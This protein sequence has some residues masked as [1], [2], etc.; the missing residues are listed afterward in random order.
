ML[1]LKRLQSTPVTVITI[2]SAT[3]LFV[4]STVRHLLFQSTAFEMGIYDQVTY[5][6]S[7]GLPPFSTFLEVH[8]LGNHAAWS[9]YPVALFYKIYPSVYWL[10]LIQ[11]I[12]LAIGALPTWSLARHTGLNKKQSFA[13]A[14]VYLLYPVVF[15]LN[16]FDFHPEVMALPAILGAI[17]AAKL[18]KTVWFSI[19]IIWVLGCKAVLSLPIAA[20]GFWLYFFEKKRLCGAIALF[21]GSA[22]FIIAAQVMIPFFRGG[23][24]PGGLGR[25]EYLGDSIPG[26]LLNMFLRPELVIGRVISLK[27]LEY[28]LLLILPIFWWISPKYLTPLLAASPVLTLNILSDIDAQRDLIH[29]YSLPILPFLLMSIIYT[30]ADGKSGLW[31]RV[32]NFRKKQQQENKSIS[33]FISDRLPKFMVIWSL[34]GFLALAKYGYFWSIY[35][36]YL[37]TWQ[38]AGSAVALVNTK[39]GVLTTS[40]IAPH[41]THRQFIKLIIEEEE[42]PITEELVEFDYVLLNVRHPGWKSSREYSLRLLEKLKNT[43][44][45][46]LSYQQDD[47]YLFQILNLQN[48]LNSRE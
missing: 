13:I 38:A 19:A 21:V 37:D 36:D 14:M 41:L 45:F 10:L 11:A 39:G 46:E 2:I 9:I 31:Y 16:L 1:I 25:Y 26:I 12:C 18:D 35:L 22:W 15:N 43:S 30:I 27:T 48:I 24:G 5:L 42:L 7:Q 6:I 34:I 4:C 29:Q 28:L 40:E 20:M 33:K 32:W 8:H 17:L 3:I 44:E 47:V 23:E